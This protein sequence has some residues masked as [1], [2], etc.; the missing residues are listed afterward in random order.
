M[1]QISN[2]YDVPETT[3]MECRV[4]GRIALERA[5]VEI[6]HYRFR[7]PQGGV[8][9]SRRGF[10]DL[11]LSPRPG[12]PQG[13]YPAIA[14]SAP[15]PLGDII[16]IPANQELETEWGEGEQTS[17]CCAFDR[18]DVDGEGHILD[19]AALEASLDVR[20]VYVRDALQ[21]L[22]REI[23]NPG[24]CSALLAEAIWTELAIEL[25][26]YLMRPREASPGSLSRLSTTQLRRIDEMI[27]RPGRLPTI[28]ELAKLCDVSTRHFFRIFRASTG[29]TLAGYATEK[30][31]DRAK[32][33]LSSPRPAV[34]E[35]AWRCGFETPAAFSAAF[36]RSVGITPME[37]RQSRKH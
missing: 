28:A 16:F 11:A 23:E 8:F 32:Q 35:V 22:A 1:G 14:G 10:L 12:T 24:L 9:R 29:R 7:G 31:I 17:V 33:L 6:H 3:A 36:R 4:S 15:Q 25:H 2:V 5:T 19:S 30:R 37:F 34:K 27:D 18:V 13:A 26:R 20:N 21:R